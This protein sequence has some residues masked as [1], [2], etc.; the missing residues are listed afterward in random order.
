MFLRFLALVMKMGLLGLRRRDHYFKEPGASSV[1]YQVTSDSLLYTI[2]DCGFQGYAE[3]DDLPD[4]RI[5]T[6]TD[7]LKCVRR[8]IDELQSHWQEVFVL[9]S[10][11]VID[12]S[13]VG[14]TGATNVHIIVL[15]NKPTSRG[16][17]L[18][19]LW[20]AHSCWLWS[21]WRTS[22]SRVRCAM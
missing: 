8:Y 15:P 11:F 3:G 21:L 10:L 12:E 7:P 17:R 20:D 13:M 16:V 22:R 9:V 18:K 19:T 14:W 6:D 1:V 2:R 4:G 5:A